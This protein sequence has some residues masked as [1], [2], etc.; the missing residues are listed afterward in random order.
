[1][2]RTFGFKDLRIDTQSFPRSSDRNCLTPH[3]RNNAKDFMNLY[4]KARSQNHINTPTLARSSF[5]PKSEIQRQVNSATIRPSS[6]HLQADL[7]HK[8]TRPTNPFSTGRPSQFKLNH[9][10]NDDLAH[11]ANSFAN[12]TPSQQQENYIERDYGIFNQ[13]NLEQENRNEQ[14]HESQLDNAI[15][16]AENDLATARNIPTRNFFSFST[17][18]DLSKKIFR[19]YAISLLAYSLLL[20]FHAHL[21]SYHLVFSLIWILQLYFI[22]HSLKRPEDGQTRIHLIFGLLALFAFEVFGFLRLENV[23]VPLTISLIPVS[24]SVFISCYLNIYRSNGNPQFLGILIKLLAWLQILFV[25][26]KVDNFLDWTWQ[27][28]FCVIW[29][30]LAAASLYCLGLVGTF[31]F[32]FFDQST[33]SR[34][35]QVV[36]L[37]WISFTFS[38]LQA[39]LDHEAP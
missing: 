3:Q 38:R 5:H 39:R 17:L 24:F 2:N 14:E 23:H 9:M 18:D 27:K 8:P 10:K 12:E 1:M 13:E 35:P 11:Q 25:C 6:I 20:G 28:V 7:F 32:V 21:Y 36:G 26:L 19:N 31:V 15:Q 29:T 22:Y 33:N 16:T 34:D 37:A 30:L 4:L